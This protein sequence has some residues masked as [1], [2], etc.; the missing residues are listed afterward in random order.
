MRRRVASELIQTSGAGKLDNRELI[1]AL[2]ESSRKAF[3]ARRPAEWKV[4]VGGYDMHGSE[5]EAE[6]R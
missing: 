3:Q 2:R 5:V 4:G 6:S 1:A